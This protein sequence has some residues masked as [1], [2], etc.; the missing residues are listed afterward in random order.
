MRQTK[1]TAI[2]LHATD[3]FDADR[4]YLMFTREIGKLRARA[5]GAR[6]PKSRLAGNLL[7]YTPTSLELVASEGS[8]WELIV[9]AQAQLD[10]GYPVEPLA[11]FEHTELLAEAI[12]KLLPDREA[13]PEFFDG[14]LFTLERLRDRCQSEPDNGLLLLIVAELIFKYLIMLGYHPEL[15]RCV[16]TGDDLAPQGLGWS[17]H[18]GGV[19]SEEGMRRMSVPSFPIQAKSVVVLRQLARPQFV[20]ERL[21]MDETIQREA[22]HIVFDYL[23][24]QI[25]K[26][27]KSYQVRGRKKV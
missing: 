18:V 20:A 25:G 4:S 27:L 11:F 19:I 10:G 2:I 3:I 22:S 14:L 12:D 15:E 16:V 13:H 24:T 6:R 7:P 17:S 23:Q 21:A 1:V 5:K 8:D 9:Q 26:P